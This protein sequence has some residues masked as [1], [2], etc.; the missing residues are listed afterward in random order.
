MSG[1][2]LKP[3]GDQTAGVQPKGITQQYQLAA[4]N[5]NVDTSTGITP[6]DSGTIL[7]TVPPGKAGLKLVDGTVQRAS[8]LL[9]DSTSGN[10]GNTLVP[11]YNLAGSGAAAGQDGVPTPPTGSTPADGL[12]QA[13]CTE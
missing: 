10:V 12:S 3:A 5:S 7:G 1:A 6:Y 11:V 2:V 8:Q 4:T 13:P 9:S